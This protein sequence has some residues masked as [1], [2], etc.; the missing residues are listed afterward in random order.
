MEGV[1]VDAGMGHGGGEV[2]AAEPP[3][4]AW[5][6]EERRGARGKCQKIGG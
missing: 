2:A 3:G 6:G 5:T 1:R 4:G